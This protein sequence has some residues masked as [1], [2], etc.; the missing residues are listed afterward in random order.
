MTPLNNHVI[1][2]W[3]GVIEDQS[4]FPKSI[5]DCDYLDNS[6]LTPQVQVA[7]TTAYS[8]L[9]H[10]TLKGALYPAHTWLLGKN[11]F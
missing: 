6:L 5:Y 7:K 4:R 3:E 8:L 10:S 2:T 1:G 11:Y 9:L